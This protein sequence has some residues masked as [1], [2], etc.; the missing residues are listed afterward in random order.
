M[1]CTSHGPRSAVM[2]VTPVANAPVTRRN[3]TGSRE[4]MAMALSFQDNTVGA[5]GAKRGGIICR[6]WHPC[7]R[8][9]I[10]REKKSRSSS[11][12]KRGIRDD[13]VGNGGRTQGE[14]C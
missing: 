13:K 4:E 14:A 12:Q 6:C 2:T 7:A 11:R 5:G 8:V 3:V 10:S 9:I 1:P